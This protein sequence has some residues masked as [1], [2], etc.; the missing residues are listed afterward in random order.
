MRKNFTIIIYIKKKH[1]CCNSCL[2]CPCRCGID[3]IK[4][5]KNCKKKEEKEC[6]KP[7]SNDLVCP[8]CKK[9][10]LPCPDRCPDLSQYVLKTSVP[11]CPKCPDM[12]K[13]IRKSEIPPPLKCPDMDKF[14]LKS[15]VPPCPQCQ[16]C[17][18][19]NCGDCPK[20][21]EIPKPNI[22][23]CTKLL[24]KN[25]PVCNNQ[26]VQH[27]NNPNNFENNYY[28]QNFNKRNQPL[29]QNNEGACAPAPF[30]NLGSNTYPDS[31]SKKK[32]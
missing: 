26:N 25:C 1:P 29:K 21:P 24:K 17:P 5:K 19:C 15:S 31:Y 2:K 32:K 27:E 7:P 11:P 23:I 12:D 3:K 28:T 14:V 10:P 22:K 9:C 13:Y 18:S 4:K 6:N 16:E 20:C 30:S 8:P